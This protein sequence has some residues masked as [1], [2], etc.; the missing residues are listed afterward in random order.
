[1]EDRAAVDRSLFETASAPRTLAGDDPDTLLVERLRRRV[2]VDHHPEVARLRDRL[3]DRST[4]GP[5][6]DRPTAG[7]RRDLAAAMEPDV[8]ALIRLRNRL[9]RDLG[10]TSY[11]HLAMAA[12]GL[13][14]DALVA[15]MTALRDAALP[16]ARAFAATAGAT[17]ETWFDGLARVTGPTSMD[18]VASG[19]ELAARLGCDDLFGRVRWTVRDGPIA[20]YTAAVS[21]PDDVRILVRPARSLRDL[22]TGYHELGHA[23]AYAGTRVGGIRAIPSDTQDE[24]MGAVLERIGTLLM[25]PAA[26]RP[27]L[28]RIAL[29]ETARTATSFLF[30]ASIQSDPALARE[31]FAA[32]YAPL[33]AIPDPVVWALESF[34][35]IDPFRIHAYALGAHFADT[36]VAHLRATCGDDHE[37]WGRWLRDELWS[38]GRR[39]TFVELTAGVGRLQDIDFRQ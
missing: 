17:I 30:E 4:Y 11:G 36:L 38:Q 22:T 28:D 32:W 31:A 10:A 19:R 20:G 33:V 7:W 8:I 23:F 2:L 6:P 18:V 16:E 29:A 27:R 13:D 35:S 3:D 37:A 25:L 21:I 14:L 1:M 39:Q 5:V 12:E 15:T 9:A 24:T 26:V 34:H